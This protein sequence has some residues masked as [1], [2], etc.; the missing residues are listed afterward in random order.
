MIKSTKEMKNVRLFKNAQNGKPKRVTTVTDDYGNRVHIVKKKDGKTVQRSA[1]GIYGVKKRLR[2]PDLPYDDSTSAAT[3]ERKR[4]AKRHFRSFGNRLKRKSKHDD[5]KKSYHHGRHSTIGREKIDWPSEVDLKKNILASTT[6]VTRLIHKG[7]R[8]HKKYT[9]DYKPKPRDGSTRLD[10][11]M[12]LRTYRKKLKAKNAPTQMPK[13]P[14]K[15]EAP[16]QTTPTQT[17]KQT[18]PKSSPPSDGHFKKHKTKYLAGAGAGV[19]A[20]TGYAAKKKYEERKSVKSR[21]K[22]ALSR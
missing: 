14:S 3:P 20:G 9:D 2:N 13:Q 7:Q 22:R 17:T 11:A 10:K 19:V 12:R 8:K 5:L 6:R 18:T 21:V 16:K 1:G 4:M 15:T